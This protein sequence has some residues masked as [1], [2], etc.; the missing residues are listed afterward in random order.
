MTKLKLNGNGRNGNG[1]GNGNGHGK[2]AAKIALLAIAVL[3]AGV[4]L[5]RQFERFSGPTREVWVASGNL[6][7]GALLSAG[8]F[9]RA[10]F[11]ERDLPQDAVEAG[12]EGDLEGRQLVRPKQE[13]EPFVRGDVTTP[14]TPEQQAASLAELLPEGRVLTTVRVD[15]MSV[16][17]NELRF[18]DRFEIVAAGGRAAA[19]VVASDAYFLAWIDPSLLA[20][21]N[22]RQPEA[23]ERPRGGFLASL[24]A[25][26]PELLNR[27][28]GGG[29]AAGSTNLLL[30]LYPEDVLPVKHAEAGGG[31]SLV[32]HGKRE[33][34]EGRM[35]QLPAGG[36][37]TVELIAGDRRESVPVS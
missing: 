22:Q 31:L 4:L 11:R 19:R 13:G 16:L 17:M 7:A 23:S 1:N 5:F 12:P 6:S 29:G 9:Q 30:A 20:E 14:R 33:V 8:D 26:P 28:G 32:L 24:L 18:G 36:T 15:V 3:A 2:S 35:L 25:T 10:S 21:Q 37:S 34:D 27:G